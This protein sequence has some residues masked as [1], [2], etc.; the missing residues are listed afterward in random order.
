ML[1]IFLTL[2]FQGRAGLRQ[3]SPVWVLPVGPWPQVPFLVLSMPSTC[4]ACPPA[5]M[6]VLHLHLSPGSP[7]DIRD[8]WVLPGPKLGGLGSG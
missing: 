5:E 8:T 3:T 4:T 1:G 6:L 2:G 7:M